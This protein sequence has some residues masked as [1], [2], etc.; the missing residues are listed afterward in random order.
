MPDRKPIANF[1]YS[2]F[3][4]TVRAYVARPGVGYLITVEDVGP[5]RASARVLRCPGSRAIHTSSHRFDLVAAPRHVVD[6][7]F[8]LVAADGPHPVC[9]VPEIHEHSIRDVLVVLIDTGS[10]LRPPAASQAGPCSL[11]QS[12]RTSTR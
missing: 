4:R 6:F 1:H 7:T 5:E 3:S 11:E 2:E 9:F 10:I 12:T 8:P